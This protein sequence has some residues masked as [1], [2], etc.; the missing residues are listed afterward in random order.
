MRTMQATLQLAGR[1][2]RMYSE[3]REFIAATEELLGSMPGRIDPIGGARLPMPSL[4]ARPEEGKVDATRAKAEPAVAAAASRAK[5][6]DSEAITSNYLTPGL[7][8]QPVSTVDK[9]RS[10]TPNLA[11]QESTT[12]LEL[13]VQPGAS[14]DITHLSIAQDKDLNGSF[15]TNLT[16]PVPVSGI[17]A[18]GIMSCD[19]GTWNN[20]RSFQWDV[21]ASGDVVA[22]SPSSS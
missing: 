15:D 12:M 13:L 16:V 9:S 22:S 11:C 1:D 17:C 18:N 6:S 8:N 7:A 14:G 2:L 4:F 19:Q 20:C 5:S 10:F 21:A 3:K